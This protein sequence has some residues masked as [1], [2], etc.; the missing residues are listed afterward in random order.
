MFYRLCQFN[1][2]A[3]I[4]NPLI[5]LAEKNYDDLTKHE[6]KRFAPI[7]RIS[8]RISQTDSGKIRNNKGCLKTDNVQKDK[9]PVLTFSYIIK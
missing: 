9:I 4:Y 7:Q 3:S 1:I 8:I 5:R 2:I 6:N